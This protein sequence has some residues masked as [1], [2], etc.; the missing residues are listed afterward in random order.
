M[1]VAVFDIHRFERE[2]LT[3]A[4]TGRHDLVLLDSR[5]TPQSAK[6][7]QGCSAACIFVNDDGGREVLEVLSKLGIHYVALRSAGYNHIDLVAAEELGIQVANVPEYSPHAVAEHTVALIL[8]LNR[9]IIRAH[10]R[11][12]EHNFSLDGLVGFDLFGKT[13][14]IV[15]TG[16]IG[17]VV[18]RIMRGFGC[19]LL[20]CDPA[21]N[22]ALQDEL[23]VEYTSLDELCACADIIT[24]HSPLTAATRYLINAQRLSTMKRGVMLINT[25]RGGLIDTKATIDA[26]K[27]GQVGYLGIDVYEEEAGIFF[28]DH[29]EHVLQ[30]DVLSRLTTF[31]NVLITSHQAF[32]TDTAL[33]NIA[34]TTMANISG[35]ETS[36]ECAHDL[37]RR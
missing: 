4:A 8:A 32:L 27:S 21:P 29:S 33:R 25:S 5:L 14:G 26:L 20:A 24:L 34:E 30:D 28:E 18:A 9:R 2:F 7:A 37:V 1:R 16:R 12:M 15:G 17:E 3:A 10:N 31:R 23:S 6:L 22:P 11:V 19:R 13:V 35:W 36:G